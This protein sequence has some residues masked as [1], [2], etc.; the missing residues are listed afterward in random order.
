MTFIGMQLIRQ[1]VSQ[2]QANLVVAEEQ[3][4]LV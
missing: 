4:L 1:K 2:H 3:E